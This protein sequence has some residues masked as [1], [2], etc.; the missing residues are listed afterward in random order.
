MAQLAPEDVVASMRRPEVI[1]THAYINDPIKFTVDGRFY[2]ETVLAQIGEIPIVDRDGANFAVIEYGTTGK[3]FYPI[4]MTSPIYKH[5]A[6]KKHIDH[7]F[8]EF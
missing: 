3:T 7:T 2:P 8:R 6:V 4:P 5:A 1:T